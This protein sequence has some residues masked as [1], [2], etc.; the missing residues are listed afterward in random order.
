M[1]PLGDDNADRQRWPYV[2]AALVAINVM[3]FGYELALDERGTANL[4]QFVTNWGVVPDELLPRQEYLTILTSMFLHGGWAHLLGN[5]LYLWIFGDN[6]E[7]RLGRI[8]FILFY[9]AAGVAAAGA[10]VIADPHS[11]V[12]MI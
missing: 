2:T 8:P 12:P 4:A 5:M 9:L 11:T 7:D 3:V 6:V 10:Q 1:L